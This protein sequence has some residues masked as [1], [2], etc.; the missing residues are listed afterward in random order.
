MAKYYY[1]KNFH[2]QTRKLKR[3]QTHLYIGLTAILVAVSGLGV[4]VWQQ[5]SV[6]NTI[7]QVSPVKLGVYNGIPRKEYVNEMFSFSSTTEWTFIREASS[8][9]NRYVF[10]NHINGITQYELTVYVDN[11]PSQPVGYITP[12]IVKDQKII[13][14]ITSQRCGADIKNRNGSVPMNFE[15]VKYSCDLVNSQQ[16]I[17][18]GVKGGGYA[19]PLYNSQGKLMHVGLFFTDHSPGYRPEVFNEVLANFKLR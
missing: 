6:D 4:Y 11:I 12:V 17:G 1:K 7:Q 19:I 16:K 5:I 15:D 13:P 8:P 18:A 3:A 2:K 9:P 10:Y 14:G